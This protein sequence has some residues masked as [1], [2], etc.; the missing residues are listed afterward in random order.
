[1]PSWSATTS[2][3]TPLPTRTAETGEWVFEATCDSE[4]DLDSFAELA[5]ATLGGNVDFSVEPLD[6]EVDWVARSL[7]GLKPVTAGGFYIH[8][9]HDD[10]RRRRP[11]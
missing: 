2:P 11:A 5:R 7:E 9:S 1:M 3:S 10:R 6:P 4:P 8:G